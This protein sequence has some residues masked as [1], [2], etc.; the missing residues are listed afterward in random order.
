[1]GWTKPED[2]SFCELF[3]TSLPR[4]VRYLTLTLQMKYPAGFPK[5]LALR[6]LDWTRIAVHWRQIGSPRLDT[7]VLALLSG[8]G[9]Q[10]IITDSLFVTMVHGFPHMAGFMGAS[11]LLSPVSASNLIHAHSHQPNDGNVPRRGT[12]GIGTVLDKLS[13]LDVIQESF[14]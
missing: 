10:E 11:L 13:E 2:A 7:V 3:L 8:A 9:T 6:A 5:D 1:M 14:G 4:S 12:Y